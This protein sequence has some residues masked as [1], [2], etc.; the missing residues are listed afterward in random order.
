MCLHLGVR[1]THD[2]QCKF[3]RLF[4]Y[5]QAVYCRAVSTGI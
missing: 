5:L 1:L 4:V 2:R 3:C